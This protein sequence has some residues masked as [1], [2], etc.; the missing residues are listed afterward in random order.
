M[1]WLISKY[2]WK[3]HDSHDL[4]TPSRAATSS[5]NNYSRPHYYQ[6]D[7]NIGI[8]YGTVRESVKVPSVMD[9]YNNTEILP[10]E[11]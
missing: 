8:V 10:A 3:F 1:S 5:L 4:F 9:L 2:V 11:C 6:E 7:V